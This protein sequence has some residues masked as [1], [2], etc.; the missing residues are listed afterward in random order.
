MSVSRRLF[1]AGSSATGLTLAFAGCSPRTTA[2]EAGGDLNMWVTVQPDDTVVLRVNAADI[3]QG[4]QTGLAQSVADEMDADIGKLRIEMAPASDRYMVKGDD[5]K[6][7]YTGGSSSISGD[8]FEIFADAGATARAMLITAAARRWRM[9]PATCTARDGFVI[10]PDG[11]RIAFGAVAAE[12]ARL[13]V[14]AHVPRKAKEQRRLIG[15]PVQRLDIPDKVRGA[16]VYGIDV[17]VD[18]MLTGTLAQCPWFGGTLTSVDDK[19]ALAVRGVKQV[20]TLPNAVAVLASSFHA[21]KKGLD[22]LQPHWQPP[23]DRVASQET[24]LATL[25]QHVGATDSST[26]TL[27]PDTKAQTIAKVDAAL[28]TGHVFTADYDVQLLAHAPME[29]LNATAR[30]TADSCELWASMQDQGSML[31][32]LAAAL[33]LP[34]SAI[35]LHSMRC[36]GGFGRR[37]KTDYGVLAAQV[38]R[39]AGVPVKLIWTREADFTHAFYRPASAARLRAR[40]NGDWTIAALDYSGATSNDTAVGGIG[41]NYPYGD[42]VIR[43]KNVPLQFPIGAWRSVDPSVTIFFIESFVDEIAHEA[44]LD[45]LAYRKRLLG[46]DPQHHRVLN[47]AAEMAGWGK[48]PAGRGQGLAFFNQRY[49]GTAVAQVVELSVDA[50]NHITLHKVSCAIDPG[51]AVNPNQVKAQAEGGIILGLSAALGEEI[52]VRDG[53]VEQTNFDSYTVPRLRSIPEIEVTVLET[54]G[55]PLGGAGEPPVPPIMPALANAVFAATGKRIRSLPLKRAA[56][57]V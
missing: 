11:Q 32:D 15:K 25:K 16:A 37:L 7:Y 42:V 46:N 14:P 33:S 55:V 41:R 28:A 6:G 44:Q 35:T 1:L 30:V 4:A 27:N 47:T 51:L 29:P 40:L 38:A 57:T 10:A 53:R 18:G 9:E 17:K 12:A 19:P 45:P 43:Q 31:T 2:P 34:R 26:Y 13:P 56:F 36:G 54:E 50:Q 20:I 5:P 23:A 24:M 22:A 39:R 21:A 48:A 52:T 8:Q 49:W 3:G